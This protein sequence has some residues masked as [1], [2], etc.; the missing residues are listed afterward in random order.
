MKNFL[1]FIYLLPL[2][3][4]QLD[5]VMPVHEKDASFLDIVIDEI[6]KNIQD[7]GRIIIISNQRFSDRAE[8]IDEKDFPFT[9]DDI[10]NHLGQNGGIGNHK[11]R[12]WYYQQLLKLYAHFVIEDLSEHILILDADTR[13][14]HKIGFIDNKGRAI[15]DTVNCRCCFSTYYNHMKKLLPYM[16]SINMKVNPVVHHMV[17]SREIISDLFYKIEKRFDLPFWMVF[18]NQV[19]MSYGI[20]GKGFYIGASEYMLYYHFL[21]KLPC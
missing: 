21:P 13:A 2:F 15:L 1:L 7:L 10:G 17:F 18:C 8:W 9:L 16:D 3:S 5:V 4:M 11:R 6:E 20:N 12:G 14:N 19:D